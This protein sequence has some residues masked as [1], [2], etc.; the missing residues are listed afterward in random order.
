MRG[1][2]SHGVGLAIERDAQNRCVCARVL[3]GG[4]A[5]LLLL[6]VGKELGRA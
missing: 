2:L 4:A 3:P 6:K 5:A 1:G